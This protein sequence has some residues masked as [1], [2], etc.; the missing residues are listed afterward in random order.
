M[1]GDERTPSWVG[2]PRR[3]GSSNSSSIEPD[4]RRAGLSLAKGLVCM[5][6]CRDGSEHFGPRKALE[7]RHLERAAKPRQVRMESPGDRTG[8]RIP[9]MDTAVGRSEETLSVSS[10]CL[11]CTGLTTQPW[12]Q[13]WLAAS[14]V[15]LVLQALVRWRGSRRL[16]PKCKVACLSPRSRKALWR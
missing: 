16:R 13:L 1:P 6:S 7:R 12:P 2:S 10:K 3:C 8:Y 11:C 5:A 15:L 4:S 9:V 14:F